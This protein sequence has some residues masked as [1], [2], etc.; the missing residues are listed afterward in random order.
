MKLG[1]YHSGRQNGFSLVEL[2]FFIIV[3]GILAAALMAALANTLSRAPTAQQ[4]TVAGQLAQER[5][6]LV[7]AQR[8][9]LLYSNLI[10]PC[11]LL[12]PAAICTALAGYT[13]TVAG[14]VPA[15]PAACPIAVDN[16]TARCK[17]VNVTVTGPSG[18]Q[19]AQL[20]ALITN[21]Q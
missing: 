14:A 13:V 21:Y 20:T 1:P 4:I 18:A 3:S 2:V 12:T 19:L 5:M 8:D 16:N 7:F 9:N 6:E 17:T 15:T 10:D 11:T